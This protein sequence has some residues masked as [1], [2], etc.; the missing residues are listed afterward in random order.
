MH[1]GTV[2]AQSAGPHQGSEI[3]VELPAIAMPKTDGQE[4]THNIRHSLSVT[5]RRI[6]VVDD[7]E[8]AG[9][10]MGEMLRSIGHEVCVAH[11]GPRALQALAQFTPEVAIL[12]IGLP[13][14]D[15]YEL[16]AALIEKFGPSL[17]LMAV[18]GYGQEQDKIRTQR[19]GF[20]AHF[21]KPVGLGKVL[22]AIEVPPK[23]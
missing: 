9:T 10:L 5:P 8:D 3:V 15:G 21:V 12:D 20:E 6:L 18:T 2:H 17:R 23:A 13:V 11:D 4:P 19:A 7:N 14:M 1:A 16:A 22:A